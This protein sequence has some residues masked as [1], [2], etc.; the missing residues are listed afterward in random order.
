MDRKYLL[1]A[2]ATAGLGHV[3]TSLLNSAYY[4][5]R[6]GRV[7]ALDMRNFSYFKT[8]TH[9]AFFENFGFEF[10]P[11]LE[12]ITDLTE[13]ERI[14]TLPDQHC[15]TYDEQPDPEHPHKH[16]VVVDP[17]FYHADTYTLARRHDG[18]PFRI[19]LRGR[20]LEEW[21]KVMSRPEWSGPV[22]GMHYRCKPG[23]IHPRLTKATMPD[24]DERYQ[25]VKDS[26]IETALAVAKQA[27]YEN[28]AFLVASD[29]AGFVSY[30]KER[31]PNAFSLA[32][33]LPDQ[34]ILS[35]VRAHGH[36]FGI[37][38]DAVNDM[39]C[40]SAC[41][42]FLYYHSSFASFAVLN[43]RKL[44]P[45]TAHYVHVPDLEEILHSL[46]PEAAVRYGRGA[47]RKAQAK[48]LQIFHLH[49]WFA[50]ALERAGY[51]EEATLER[52][53]NAWHAE[54]LMSD[55]TRSPVI[56]FPDLM[57]QL[58][59][60]DHRGLLA[61]A[62]HA[63]DL[64]P[65]NPYALA[66]FRHSLS[67]VLV[68]AGR[69]QEALAPAR[70]A[71]EIEPHDPFLH[72]HLGMVLARSGDEEAAEDAIRTAIR[73]DPEIGDFHTDL[74]ESLL[75]QNRFDEALAEFRIAASC[76]SSEP[77][78]LRRIGELLIRMRD[79]AGAESV[80]RQA[81]ALRSEAGPHSDLSDCFARQGRLE[82]AIAAARAAVELERNNPMWHSR[83]AG[84]LLQTNRF[85]EAEAA[86]REAIALDP[87]APG[88]QATLA[89]ALE[90]QGRTDEAL[91]EAQRAA[92]ATPNDAERRALV[93]TILM[94]AGRYQEAEAAVA[95]A[96]ELQPEAARF[97]D[98][99]ATIWER[100]NRL[101]DAIGAL[102]KAAELE[103]DDAGRHGRLGGLLLRA[104]R[105]AETEAALRRATELAGGVLGYHHML[106]IAI[107]RQGRLPEAVAQARRVVELAPDNPDLNSRL[108]I[109]LAQSG[110]AGE[111]EAVLTR[112]V[113]A[114]PSNP[115]LYRHLCAL[116]EQQQRMSEAI[117]V[118]RKLA[119]LQPDQV[120]HL[121]YLAILFLRARRPQDAERVLRGAIAQ[122]PDVVGLHEALAEALR[123]QGNVQAAA[124]ALEL[125]SQLPGAALAV[126]VRA[127]RMLEHA[128]LLDE[129]EAA[130]R[131]ATA[132]DPNSAEAN[133]GLAA[134][135]ERRQPVAAEPLPHA[136]PAG[137]TKQAELALATR[138]DQQQ[139]GRLIDGLQRAE[140]TAAELA[141]PE[142]P[143][144]EVNAALAFPM[145]PE[146]QQ[147]VPTAKRAPKDERLLG[148]FIRRAWRSG[149]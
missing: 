13:V 78:P 71:L 94:R 3:F 133:R 100:Q 36:D 140:P 79:F 82:D 141:H 43:S 137:A 89:Q 81:I 112:N 143:S 38:A 98:L 1:F 136:M 148:R 51:A 22:I 123:Q 17:C 72:A 130:W 124:L 96:I 108:A 25:A 128:D 6:T 44:G 97:H 9:A 145:A 21:R 2:I 33:N 40:L 109:L 35:Y 66:G 147:E 46:E 84:L 57:R 64:H 55:F 11:E 34:Y 27:G 56:S 5:W 88:N 42:H 102:R 73:F 101:D 105:Y 149:R 144:A 69:P 10:P 107:E 103:P 85:S 19:V 30:I 139:A 114:H 59:H 106:G 91:D 90:K 70:R 50:D 48:R 58:N 77:G 76:D 8:D 61:V 126:H 41:D 54:C 75:R 131:R 32:S 39:W 26:Y 45:K 116:F 95:K 49:G 28:P 142:A 115:H 47:V 113:A 83:L 120:S 31:L 119:E 67:T 29:D 62:Q 16:Q 37:L 110:D 80:I 87:N 63:V 74:A 20:L 92:D 129:A 68:A 86:V 111:A 127:A 93:G 125:A 138:S 60:G 135:I 53:R 52:Q 99:M 104:D 117:E 134:L 18:T 65:G 122:H 132:A 23:E 7:L 118:M 4:A 15:L 24:F 14:R 121:S 12:I 146:V